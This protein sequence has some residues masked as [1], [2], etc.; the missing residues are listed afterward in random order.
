MPTTVY[1]CKVTEK[2]VFTQYATHELIDDM[3]YKVTGTM[4][5]DEKMTYNTG[6]NKSEEAPDEDDDDDE[7]NFPESSLKKACLLKNVSHNFLSHEKMSDNRKAYQ[8][9][10]SEYIAK[11][12][13]KDKVEGLKDKLMESGLK[14]ALKDVVMNNMKKAE[15]MFYSTEGD[16]YDNLGIIIPTLEYGDKEG[17]KVEMFVWKW[18]V[19]EDKY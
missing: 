1:K 7:G 14:V 9:Q 11:V 16:E 12:E 17:D 18:A 4:T 6:Q 15:F 5:V 19:Y 8:A 2:E 13:E 10:L 3:Y